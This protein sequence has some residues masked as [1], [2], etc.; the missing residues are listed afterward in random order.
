M[1]QG[2]KTPK[3][4]EGGNKTLS[5]KHVKRQ[6]NAARTADGG[7]SGERRVRK[8]REK[9]VSIEDGRADTVALEATQRH[10]KNESEVVMDE[11]E[12]SAMVVAVDND[13]L[14]LQRN[15][16][17]STDDLKRSLS[18]IGNAEFEIYAE[19]MQDQNITTTM[20]PELQIQDL[21]AMG[22]TIGHAIE[23]CQYHQTPCAPY[24]PS[25]NRIL[26]Q[27][28]SS[29]SRSRSDSVLSM[30]EST[31]SELAYEPQLPANADANRYIP[32]TVGTPEHLGVK[33]EDE[34]DEEEF[35]P[36]INKYI[37]LD[38]NVVT[39]NFQMRKLIEI[40]LL[41]HKFSIEFTCDVQWRDLSRRLCEDA[42]LIKRRK[43][44]N[45]KNWTS[46]PRCP[47]YHDTYTH[48]S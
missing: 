45:C 6:Q 48:I 46:R 2:S 14:V 29:I 40:K 24:T 33:E 10:E 32:L 12:S 13:L 8:E 15:A 27:L 43:H 11:A 1:P 16:I 3:Q 25:D 38:P 47:V 9:G 30:N 7:G 44:N 37:A 28:S 4:K 39:V 23:F 5:K 20:F 26:K 21:R 41:E 34:E 17:G 35:L 19:R 22:F 18:V 42:N 36:T 31:M